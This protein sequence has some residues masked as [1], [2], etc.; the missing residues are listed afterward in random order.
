MAEPTTR[1]ECIE[2]HK[3]YS[4]D[5]STR[6]AGMQRER[7]K[8]MVTV[9]RRG[10]KVLDVGCNS[11]YIGQFL[12]PGC[13]AHGVDVSAELVVKA[14]RRLATAQVAE[15]ESLPHADKSMDVVILGE[16]LEHVHDPVVCLREA[17][18]VSR[19][20]VVGSTPHEAGKWGPNGTKKPETHAFHVRCFTE[21]TLRGTLE[22]SGLKDVRIKPILR[23]GVPQVYVFSGV[24]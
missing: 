15:A 8:A 6:L 5:I 3:R 1:E 22:A 17:S 12:P 20:Y 4:I 11:G 24:V 21:A 23:A 13:E 10:D 7:L 16:I 19:R 9:V 2:R 18:R 14:K